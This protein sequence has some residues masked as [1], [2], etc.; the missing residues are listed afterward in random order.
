MTEIVDGQ[1]SMLDLDTWSGRTS[2]EHSVATAEK[3]SVPSSKKQ[4][5]SQ[6]K[7][8]LFLNLQTGNGQPPEQSWETNG[9]SL[10]EFSTRSFGESPSVAVVSR[11]SQILEDNPHQ[12]YFLSATACAGI[13]RRAEK[14]GKELPEI[15]RAALERQAGLSA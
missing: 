5:T 6:T 11:L 7:V 14:R 1:V 2:P 4:R 10:G 3:I 8:P 12:K 15:L 9:V 13:L